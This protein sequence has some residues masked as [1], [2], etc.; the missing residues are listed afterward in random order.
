MKN[1]FKKFL[2]LSIIA[3]IFL[4]GMNEIE[5]LEIKKMDKSFKI[6]Q[7]KEKEQ[8]VESTNIFEIYHSEMLKNVLGEIEDKKIEDESKSE[9]ET[10]EKVDLTFQESVVNFALQFVGNPYVMGGTSLTNGA[11][12]SGFVQSVFANFGINLPR[13]TYGQSVSG[14]SITLDDIR[15][16]DIISYG[17]DGYVTHSA[18]Y[19]GNGTI[20]HASI[21]ELGIRTDT[22]YLT[23]PIVA[24]RRVM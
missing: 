1:L 24:I 2:V 5:A 10:I 6:Y 8:V 23:T 17:Y 7:I 13:T 16:G 14:V 4:L 9:N 21:P 15:V 12:C 19:I 3:T 22:M 11:D 18:I 20:I